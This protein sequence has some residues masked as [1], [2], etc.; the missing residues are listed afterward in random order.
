MYI[1]FDE[2]NVIST[3]TNGFSFFRWSFFSTSNVFYDKFIPE[4]LKGDRAKCNVDGFV[5]C[6]YWNYLKMP[7]V[8]EEYDFTI[9]SRLELGSIAVIVLS[10][11]RQEFCIWEFVP[12]YS[13]NLLLFCNL[14]TFYRI[15]WFCCH[16]P[17]SVRIWQQ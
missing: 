6:S 4:Y 1:A 3:L 17:F 15:C 16:C 14:I 8:A 13:V 9:L 12:Q 5:G 10:L 7:A 2:I 11:I